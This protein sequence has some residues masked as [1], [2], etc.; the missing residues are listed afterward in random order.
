MYRF[1]CS[2]CTAS[3]GKTHTKTHNPITISARVPPRGLLFFYVCFY[4]FIVTTLRKDRVIHG[5][6][7]GARHFATPPHR[8]LGA[9]NGPHARWWSIGKGFAGVFCDAGSFC[10]SC[11]CKV[12][13]SL[14]HNGVVLVTPPP[15][16]LRINKDREKGDE[17][18]HESDREPAACQHPISAK[19]YRIGRRQII[20]IALK[21]HRCGRT[22]ASRWWCQ[23]VLS[24]S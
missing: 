8:L 12:C 16:L 11:V 1:Q 17:G 24:V 19:H 23:L 21:S 9:E 22:S 2:K 10:A 20:F 15:P 6:G 4:Y 5:T 18:D 3:A 14:L 13:V 7:R